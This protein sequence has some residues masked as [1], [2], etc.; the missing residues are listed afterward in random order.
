MKREKLHKKIFYNSSKTFSLDRF[1]IIICKYSGCLQQ[2]IFL[3]I[4]LKGWVIF[5]KPVFEFKLQPISTLF[6]TAKKFQSHKFSQNCQSGKTPGSINFFLK[7]KTVV[8]LNFEFCVS[9]SKNVR[10]MDKIAKKFRLKLSKKSYF[11]HIRVCYK[12]FCKY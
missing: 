10:Y 2:N 7:I 1:I 6:H 8:D 12:Q 5:S 9:K 11:L 3:R 4:L